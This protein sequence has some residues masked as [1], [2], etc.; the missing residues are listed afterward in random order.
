MEGVLLSIIAACFGRAAPRL[1]A[2]HSAS[3]CG[4]S[5]YA[6]MMSMMAATVPVR[7]R[8]WHWHTHMTL[9]LQIFWRERNVQPCTKSELL[10]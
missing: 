3:A 4:A 2:G 10:E 6:G 9:E 1:G 5:R 8:A 7:Q